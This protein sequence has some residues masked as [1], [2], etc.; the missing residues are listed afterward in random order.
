[1]ET[2]STSMEDKMNLL[3]L[4]LKAFLVHHLVAKWINKIKR[5]K[6]EGHRIKAL[7]VLLDVANKIKNEELKEETPDEI[8][9][10]YGVTVNNKKI[11]DWGETDAEFWK[12][13]LL[14]DFN[15][16]Y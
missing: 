7:Y 3:K 8:W 16:R 15:I 2:T 10:Q 13:K 9:K 11:V 14:N 12:N 5:L 1:M 4:K 6:E